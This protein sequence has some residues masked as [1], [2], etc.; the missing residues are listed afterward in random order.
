MSKRMPS[1]GRGTLLVAIVVATFVIG[2][3]LFTALGVGGSDH[4]D[5]AT[6]GPAAKPAPK[7]LSAVQRYSEEISVREAG[8][9]A[10]LSEEPPISPERFDG[11]IHAY[12]R[13]AAGQAARLQLEVDRLA[14]ATRSGDRSAA[15]A[16]WRVAFARYLRLGA[17]YGAFGDLDSAIDG[18]AGGLPHGTHDRHFTGLHRIELGLW[19]RAPVRSLTPLVAGLARNVGRLRTTIPKTKI[20]PLDYAT[21]AHEILEDAQRDFLSGVDVPWSHE[22][23]LATAAGVQATRVVID[24]LRP[25]LGGQDSLDPV[26]LGLSRMSATIARIRRAHGGR[27]PALT[28]L[29]GA[30]RERL[31][32]SLSWALERLQRIPGS[33]ETTD[34]VQIPRLPAP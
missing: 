30:E 17:V 26:V 33:L 8:G 28:D 16:A 3:A 10:T 6:T 18:Q 21:R 31:N 15:R 11:P 2:F 13:Y 9:S 4:D 34:P 14:D 20:E 1:I 29:R 19:G 7:H 12:L 27:L 25:L 5:Q 22:G 24:T 32:G 23:V